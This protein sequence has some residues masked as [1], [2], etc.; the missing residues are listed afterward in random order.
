LS[1]FEVQTLEQTVNL[2]RKVLVERN[3]LRDSLRLVVDQCDRPGG[4]SSRQRLEKVREIAEK[5][6][7]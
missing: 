3:R 1:D 7:R 5:G 6:L 2:L 4:G